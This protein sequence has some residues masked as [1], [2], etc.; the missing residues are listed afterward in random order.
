MNTVKQIIMET[1]KRMYRESVE[2]Y[3]EA[4]HKNKKDD[5]T[6]DASHG[7]YI[8]D[9]VQPEKVIIGKPLR[10]VNTANELTKLQEKIDSAIHSHEQEV[11]KARK[12]LIDIASMKD[13]DVDSEVSD[14][15]EVLEDESV[16]PELTVKHNALQEGSEL[17]SE[18]L[19]PS[20]EY[21]VSQSRRPAVNNALEENAISAKNTPENYL[22]TIRKIKEAGERTREAQKQNDNQSHGQSQLQ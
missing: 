10:E 13:V 5:K 3:N 4:R 1:I 14:A 6:I 12:H 11:A 19:Q 22:E 20:D 8:E 2:K 9:S 7:E 18:N 16:V 21:E 17:E 15:E